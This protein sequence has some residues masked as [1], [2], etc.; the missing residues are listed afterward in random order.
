[1]RILSTLYWDK[2]S[3]YK[4]LILGSVLSICVV[5]VVIVHIYYGIDIVY[6]HF[7]YLPIIIAGIWYYKKALWVALF[8]GLF[9]IAASIIFYRVI[10][11]STVA[12]AIMFLAVALVVGVISEQKEESSRRMTDII[13]FL[14]DA[15]FVIDCEGKIISWNKAIEEMT[16]VKA[17]DI[18]GKNNF[19][20][21]FLLYGSRRPDLIDL[22][23]SPDDEITDD[24]KKEYYFF[25]RDRE[26]VIAETSNC[27][28][29]GRKVFLWVKA[30]PLY[31]TQG[32]I[33]GAIETIRDITMRRHLENEMARLDRLNMIGKMA[34][35]LAH[36]IR[37]PM[38]TVRGFLQIFRDSGDYTDK[39]ENLDLMIE[40]LDR[41][42]LIITEFLSLGKSKVMNLK[43]QNLN[44]IVKAVLPLIGVGAIKSDKSIVTE[45][46]DIPDLLL[47]DKEIRQL[48]LNLAGNGLEVTP[49]G[50]RLTVKTFTDEEGVVL[51]VQ[52]QGE[53][54][55]P[56]LIDKIG[57]PFFTTK[58][59][60][61][62]LGLAVCYSIVAR[63]NATIDVETGKEGTTF[64]VRFKPSQS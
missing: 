51:A 3:K 30:T 58:D 29:M 21:S 10:D 27:F 43:V 52:D 18:L 63:H 49:P 24:L 13:N 6:T 17:L 31:D 34:A 16:G 19:E 37:N 38:T 1:M 28:V 64:F 15:T 42:N 62:G 5:L 14:P 57:T 44:K 61:T 20:H 40:E 2:F 9:H 53:G 32:S 8:L 47:D 59:H 54:I 48:I 45:L 36:E 35:S 22:V 41:A 11:P 4:L 25:Q 26:T 56:T 12:R 23:F 50:G 33:V 7:F 55:D 39:K 60:G 46:G